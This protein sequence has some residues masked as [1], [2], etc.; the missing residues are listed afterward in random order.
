MKD[1]PLSSQQAGG[2]SRP[3]VERYV[4]RLEAGEVPPR[5]NVDGDI[6]VEG[7]HRYV[8]GRLYGEEPPIQP[9]VGG[10]PDR[11]IPWEDLPIS[12]KD[13]DK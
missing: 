11:V 4:R 9:W 3:M 12:P 5:I 7:N 1:A 10:K 13:W 8:A 6:I 2:I